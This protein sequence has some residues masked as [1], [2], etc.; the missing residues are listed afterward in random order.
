MKE[1]NL[2]EIFDNNF[3]C[4][5]QVNTEELFPAIE[6]SMFIKITRLII[7]QVLELAAEN[8]KIKSNYPDNNTVTLD[9]SYVDKQS[10][11]DTINQVV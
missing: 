5:A 2:E 11:L 8:A 10:I 4:Y 1:I 7:K 3:D 9:L 6:K